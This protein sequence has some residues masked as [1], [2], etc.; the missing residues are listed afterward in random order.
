MEGE[1]VGGVPADVPVTPPASRKDPEPPQAAAPGKRTYKPEELVFPQL[2]SRSTE[3]LWVIAS[4]LGISVVPGIQRQEL[5]SQ[6][7]ARRKELFPKKDEKP[8]PPAGAL[9]NNTN[10]DEKG[11]EGEGS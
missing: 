10:P 9:P 7:V 5:I 2:I 4:N 1:D 8:E 6:I 11:R 3:D